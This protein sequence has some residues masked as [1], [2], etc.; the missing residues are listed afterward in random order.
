MSVHIAI[1]SL[2][3]VLLLL[4]L[5]LSYAIIRKL[6]SLDRGHAAVELNISP[7]VG[8]T[9]DPSRD[10]LQWSSTQLEMLQGDQLV[11]LAVPECSGCAALRREM[12]NIGT[13]PVPLWVLIEPGVEDALA[14]EFLAGW[15]FAKRRLASPDQFHL[16]VSLERPVATPVVMLLRDGVVVSRSHYY[17][18]IKADLMRSVML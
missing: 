13:F 16:M 14:T 3:L 1:D 7:S 10:S 6:R 4:D 12:E 5:V 2:L 9:I 17:R 15:A 18:D 8:L 11:V